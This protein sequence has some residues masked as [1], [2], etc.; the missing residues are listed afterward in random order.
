MREVPEFREYDGPSGAAVLGGLLF[1][2]TIIFC[3]SSCVWLCWSLKDTIHINLE[4]LGY[5]SIIHSSDT[6]DDLGLENI[7]NPQLE[8]DQ[9]NK[10][11]RRNTGPVGGASD[12][13]GT[14]PLQHTPAISDL[15][16]SGRS[17]ERRHTIMCV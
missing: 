16:F 7:P 14:F 12:V 10:K 1:M 13:G 6:D 11:Q 5:H 2:F 15:E 8:L 9:I 17:L 3:G 4:P